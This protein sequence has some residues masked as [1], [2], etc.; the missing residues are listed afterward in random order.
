MSKKQDLRQ[1]L[2][3]RIDTIEEAYEFMLAYAAQ[4]RQGDEKSGAGNNIRTFL[5]GA[6]AALEGMGAVL[7][8]NFQN[9]GAA[10]GCQQFIEIF[11]QDV[12]KAQAAI[13]MVLFLP[14]ISS[15]LTDNLNSSIHLR[16]LLTDM[17]LLD[18]TLKAKDKLLQ[19]T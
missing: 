9:L 14:V 7:A 16:T 2:A 11:H 13:R 19:S 4:G 12:Q 1:E 18:E 6:D 5:E 8:E 10:A 3:R 17:F 15:Q